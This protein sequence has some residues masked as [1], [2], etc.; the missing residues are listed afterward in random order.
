[1]IFLA[2]GDRTVDSVLWVP[3]EAH[4]KDI[5]G[6]EADIPVSDESANTAAIDALRDE[7]VASGVLPA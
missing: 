2:V 6:V 5:Y 7:L 3:G 4:G 1:M